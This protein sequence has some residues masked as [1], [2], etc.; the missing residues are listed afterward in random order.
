MLT[1]LIHRTPA[2]QFVAVLSDGRQ[3]DR[4][5]IAALAAS[6]HAASVTADAVQCGD[7]R[8]GDHVLTAGQAIAL[9]AALRR[10]GPSIKPAD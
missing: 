2:G 8:D 3:I 5:S 6:L 9:N 4:D 7:W 1:A 10:L